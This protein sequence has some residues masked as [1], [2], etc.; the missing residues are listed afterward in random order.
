M[1][2]YDTLRDYWGYTSFL[3]QQTEAISSL[4]LNRD[5]LL[6]KATGGGKSLC[7]QIL[8]VHTNTLGIV[9]SPLISLMKDQVDDLRQKGIRAATLNS[10]QGANENRATER[11]LGEGKINL[12]YVSPERFVSSRFIRLLKGLPL[13]IVAVDEAH[14][15]SRWGH[16]FRPEYRKLRMV[17]ET[18]PDVPVIAVTA[19]ATR[20]VKD[21][22]VRQLNLK[23]PRVLVGSFNRE[24]LYYEI[25]ASANPKREILGYL[26]SHRDVSGIIYCFSRKNTEELS[27]YLQGQGYSSLPYHA[28][29]KDNIRRKTQE[30][31][32]RDEIRVICATVAF[33]MGIDKPDIR[34]VLH[35]DLP[36]DIE[37]Y[38]QETGRAGRDGMPGEC[39]LFYDRDDLAKHLW[40]INRS[41]MD[42]DYKEVQKKKLY[43]LTRFCESPVCRRHTLLKYFGEKFPE[44]NC[45]MCDNC[46]KETGRVDAGVYARKILLCVRELNGQIGR[47]KIAGILCGLES[48]EVKSLHSQKPKSFG[49]LVDIPETQVKEWVDDL[50]FQ[51]YIMRSG[52]K[53]PVLSLT[54]EGWTYLK[55]HKN[56]PIFLSKP[57][58]SGKSSPAMQKMDLSC[59]RYNPALFSLLR[60]QRDDVARRAGLP[61]YMIFTD[62]SLIGMAAYYPRTKADFLKIKGVGVAK[63]DAYGE[64]FA[65]VI[66]H[67]CEENG[68]SVADGER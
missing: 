46:Q 33:G 38:Y 1:S 13:S 60:I 6:L 43:A 44:T 48:N 51:G 35:Y 55:G 67:F 24:N 45:G 59:V 7:Y 20:A 2:L 41:D 31:F 54:E 42:R 40:L 26:D 16:D 23:N 57:K 15:I 58:M 25:R 8:P 9:V 61:K 50:I 65:A 47:G 49:S 30:S 68:I 29:L 32:V 12:L 4:H 34:F 18:W 66:V 64:L 21:D 56:I 19:T 53:Y 39:I 36:K 5:V 62:P 28:G 14:C 11:A 27:S 17:K 63:W 10:E 52:R 37:S 3:P 22:I